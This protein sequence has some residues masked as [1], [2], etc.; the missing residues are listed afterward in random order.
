ME[1]RKLAQNPLRPE[2][3]VGGAS[4]EAIWS[5]S[6]FLRLGHPGVTWPHALF[7]WHRLGSSSRVSMSQGH[8]MPSGQADLG[9]PRMLVLKTKSILPRPHRTE[10]EAGSVTGKGEM[11]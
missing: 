6:L 4:E 8:C 2:C 3:G 11:A 1:Q 10:A 5:R 7:S 9:V